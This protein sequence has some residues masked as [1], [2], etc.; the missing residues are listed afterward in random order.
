MKHYLLFVFCL[1]G[2]IDSNSQCSLTSE[3]NK[4]R[5][6]DTIVKQ[7]IEYKSPG[8]SGADVLWDFSKL[9]PIDKKYALIY[10]AKKGSDS[11]IVGREHHTRYY[12]D[13]QKDS[14]F[15]WGFENSTTQI[16]NS[17]P[18]LLLRLPMRYGDKTQS[19]YQGEGKYCGKLH[20]STVGRNTAEADA[21]GMIILPGKDTLKHVL[22]IKMTKLICETIS[23]MIDVSGNKNNP[24]YRILPDDSIVY[25]MKQNERTVIIETYQWYAAGYRY[26]IFE[27]I[28][29]GKLSD[30]LNTEYFST[31]FFYP[32]SKHTYL[33]NDTANLELQNKKWANTDIE[34]KNKKGENRN[35]DQSSKF[36][37]D[38]L[39]NIYPNPVD[40]ELTFEYYI[41]DYADVFY[42]LYNIVGQQLTCNTIKASPCG[43]YL[44]HI[45]MDNYPK[46]EYILQ[47]RVNEK[48]FSEK[49]IKR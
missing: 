28:R 16:E 20:I 11:I 22:R 24:S 1:C 31:A 43:V 47:I 12:Y 17:K 8:R 40:T 14:V 23:P 4:F 44:N 41:S 2:V 34:E 37:S 19:Y 45:D 35:H 10:S 33:K 42:G 49:I 18:E 21:H 13:W 3:Y 26:P 29:T 7:Q 6:N 15:L 25:A 9:S 30:S 48:I 46:G 5:V 36:V 27:T 38:F 39:Y 32:P